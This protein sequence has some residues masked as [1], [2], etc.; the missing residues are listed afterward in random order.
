[1]FQFKWGV[2]MTLEDIAYALQLSKRDVIEKELEGC[3]KCDRMW[4]MLHN[5]CFSIEQSNECIKDLCGII[6]L[7]SK[8][9]VKHS[10]KMD[11]CNVLSYAAELE[12]KY[13]FKVS[14]F[15]LYCLDLVRTNIPVDWR[16]VNVPNDIKK[17]YYIRGFDTSSNVIEGMGIEHLFTKL[18]NLCKGYRIYDIWSTAHPEYINY[19]GWVDYRQKMK[20]HLEVFKGLMANT[21]YRPDLYLLN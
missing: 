10:D 16:K 20:N 8:E 15:I 19:C 21:L 18:G 4:N 14:L 5:M 12:V 2:Y 17:I 3:I 6:P 7:I 1:M 9:L 11:W 13:R